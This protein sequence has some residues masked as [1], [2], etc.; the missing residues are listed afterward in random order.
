VYIPKADGRQRPLGVAASEDKLLQ[1]AV[2]EALN[3]VYETDWVLDADVRGF[4]DAVDH[5]WPLRFLEHRIADRRVLRPIR[6]WLQAGVIENG[7]WSETR[8]GTARGAS[9]SPLLA[10]VYLHHLFDPW[11]DQW[12]RRH[13]RGD[14]SIVRFADDYIV[15]FQPRDDAERFPAELRDRL[16]RFGLEL[17]SGKTRLIAFGRFAAERRQKRGLGKPET[18]AFLGLTHI[19]GKTS[20]GRFSS[21]ASPRRSGCRRSCARSRPSRC[22]AGICPAPNKGNGEQAWCAGISPT[23]P[24]PATARRST[25]SGSRRSDTGTARSGVAASA[26]A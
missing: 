18:F 25:P 26:A 23:T 15:G 6:R 4:Y 14:V 21:S 10:N 13:A 17:A 12:R 19:C 11:A 24:C 2:V 3:A 9:V 8:E 1:R 7:A 22:D 16:A 5:G 20:N